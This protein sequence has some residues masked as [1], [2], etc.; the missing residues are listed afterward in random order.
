MLKKDF[1]WRLIVSVLL[2]FLTVVVL[3]F[4]VT[5]L[6]FGPLREFADQATTLPATLI[7]RFVYPDGMPSGPGGPNLNGLFLVCEVIPYVI[8][9]FVV[10]SWRYRK[11]QT[12][13]M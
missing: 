4:G 12:A 7:T 9:W 13:I 5:L 1:N 8:L 11:S 3:R 10:L 2:G 6:P